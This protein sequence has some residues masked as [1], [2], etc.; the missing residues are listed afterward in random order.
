MDNLKQFCL[1]GAATAM[2][3]LAGQCCWGQTAEHSTAASATPVAATNPSEF[4]VSIHV[5][6]TKAQGELRPVWDFFGYDEPNFTY[7]DNGRKLLTELS[8]I[9]PG[10]IFIR[11]HHLLTSGDGTAALKWGST[12]AYSE[13]EN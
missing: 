5:D 6:A 12:G 13:D 11:T 8:Q 1:R 4:P 2:V 7:A 9:G 10:P 3:V